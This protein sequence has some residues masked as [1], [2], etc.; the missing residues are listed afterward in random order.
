MTDN[1][2][3]SFQQLWEN[4]EEVSKKLFDTTPPILVELVS[5]VSRLNEAFA[6]KDSEDNKHL[7]ARLIGEVVFLLTALT[8][9][10]DVNVYKLLSDQVFLNGL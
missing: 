7:K 6:N 8:Q 2:P 3:P 9:K 4:A 10:E 1:T 5:Q